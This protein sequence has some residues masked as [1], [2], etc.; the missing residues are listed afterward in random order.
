MVKNIIKRKIYKI[1]LRLSNQVIVNSY[2]FKKELD[3]KFNINSLVIF[4]PLNKLEV[5][6]KVKKKSKFNFFKKNKDKI[7]NCWKTS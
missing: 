6:K 5:Q 1:F 4:N 3:K 7:N 2:D